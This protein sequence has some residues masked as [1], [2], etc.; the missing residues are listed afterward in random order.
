MA[1]ILIDLTQIPNVKTGVA[2]YA[3]VYLKAK[4]YRESLLFISSER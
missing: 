2:I 3:K 4:G 1:N